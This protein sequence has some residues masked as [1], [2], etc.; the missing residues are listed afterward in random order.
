MATDL[1]PSSPPIDLIADSLTG[2]LAVAFPRSRALRYPLAVELAHA[3]SR[4]SE[5]IIGTVPYHLAAFGRTQDQA[6]RAFAI[7]KALQGQKAEF[8][9]RG[10]HIEHTNMLVRVLECYLKSC[11]CADPKAHCVRVI[12]DPHDYSGSGSSISAHDFPAKPLYYWPCALMLSWN[13]PKLQCP[14]PSSSED[15]LQARAVAIGC[16]ICPNFRATL[17]LV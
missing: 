6:A 16:D 10:Q 8:F 11:A 7:V 2:L 9:A 1:I 17:N 3:A 4:Y 12:G 5:S 15:Q 13:T 14:H